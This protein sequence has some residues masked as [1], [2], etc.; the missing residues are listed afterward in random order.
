MKNDVFKYLEYSLF[1]HNY[2]IIPGLGGFIVNMESVHSDL[3]VTPP[4][5]RIVFNPELN[6]DDGILTSSISKDEKISY[7]AASQR[8]KD[9]VKDLKNDL[10]SSKIITFG[11]GSFSLDNDGN[12]SFVADQAAIHP[13]LFG[14]T[15][16]A[17]K[18]LTDIKDESHKETKRIFLRNAV[19]GVAAAAAAIFLFVIPSTNISDNGNNSQQAGFIYTLANSF[20]VEAKPDSILDIQENIIS[21]ERVPIRTYYIVVGG[22]ET[23]S[24]AERLLEKIQLAGF[25]KAAIVESADRYR[26]YVASFT[27]KMEGESFLES[28]RKENPK[29]QTAWLYSK[30][31]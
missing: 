20:S 3:N 27:D 28:F 5:F 17:L 9:F 24:R 19:G 4:K 26:I 1:V 10:K 6:H 7:N 12:I 21:E 2:I 16:V 22:E 13:N 25:N 23:K 15:P 14:L 29:Y 30:R 18:Y 8:I 31:N 11:L